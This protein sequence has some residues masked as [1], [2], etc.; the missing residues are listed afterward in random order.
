[1]QAPAPQK[2]KREESVMN[3]SKIEWTSKTGAFDSGCQLFSPGCKFCYASQQSKRLRKQQLGI[4]KKAARK[5]F[6]NA[7]FSQLPAHAQASV[8]ELIQVK[9]ISK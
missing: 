4:A 2:A 1:V 9:G 7:N 3:T 6:S 8:L 5:Q